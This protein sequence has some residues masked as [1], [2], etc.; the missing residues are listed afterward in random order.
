MFIYIQEWNVELCSGATPWAVKDS[1]SYKSNLLRIINPKFH[2]NLYS[3]HW[4][5]WLYLLNEDYLP[6]LLLYHH[7]HHHHLHQLYRPNYYS[8]RLKHISPAISI[9]DICQPISTTQFSCIFLYP[10]LIC[11]LTINFVVHCINTRK[12]VQLSRPGANFLSYQLGVYYV[13]IKIV[14]TL[15]S[16]IAELAND[17][18]HNG[19]ETV[20]NCWV[21]IFN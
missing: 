18:K 2:V 10:F 9:L 17:K 1:F 6:W 3:E 19:C 5:Y 12:K 16:S 15:L 21:L 7:H 14:N 13:S 4:Q 8:C 20:F 11:N